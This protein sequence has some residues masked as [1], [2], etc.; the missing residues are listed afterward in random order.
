MK[1]IL[2]ALLASA[3]LLG[4]TACGTTDAPEEREEKH[5]SSKQDKDNDDK[6]VSVTSDDPADPAESSE[7]DPAPEAEQPP[8]ELPVINDYTMVD[9]C[10]IFTADGTDYVYNIAENKMYP[11]ELTKIEGRV[12]KSIYGKVVNISQNNGADSKFYNL[13]TGELIGSTFPNPHVSEYNPMYTHDP[14]SKKPYSF[15][16]IDANGE[17]VLPMSSEYSICEYFGQKDS[18]IYPSNSSIMYASSAYDISFYDFTKDELMKLPDT[19]YPPVLQADNLALYRINNFLYIYN[20]DTKTK[21]E[22]HND[23]IYSGGSDIIFSKN[24]YAFKTTNGYLFLD[25]DFNE[26]QGFN[27]DGYN[28]YKIVDFSE[29]KIAFWSDDPNG[30]RHLVVLDNDGNQLVAPVKGGSCHISGDYV[31]YNSNEEESYIIL[32]CAKGEK[33]YVENEFTYYDAASGKMILKK[34]GACYLA[35]LDDP[36]TLINPFAICE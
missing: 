29:D 26:L 25:L 15:G 9:G 28:V 6:E 4:I 20:F 32:N 3:M 30:N 10:M 12:I 24:G 33:T 1:K 11:T 13:E 36:N 8:K 22:I 35:S 14:S 27:L 7:T 21:T 34:D 2:C 18:Y 19:V 23:I 16:V 31:F 5:T 17:W